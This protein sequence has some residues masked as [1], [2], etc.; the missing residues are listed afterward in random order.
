MRHASAHRR[1]LPFVA[2]SRRIFVLLYK[3]ENVDSSTPHV[4]KHLGRQNK[5]RFIRKF[6][7]PCEE[8]IVKVREQS[9]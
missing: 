8:C 6:G 2:C 9:S 4:R 5:S 7:I 3:D 1:P